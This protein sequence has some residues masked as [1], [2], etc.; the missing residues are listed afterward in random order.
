M[1]QIDVTPAQYFLFLIASHAQAQG[2]H[3]R[4][5]TV[6]IKGDDQIVRLFN[7]LPGIVPRTE[8]GLF[9]RGDDPR[10]LPGAS[11]L[12]RAVLRCAL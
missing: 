1:N 2:I 8:G 7:E 5:T 3:K 10:F 9:L 12:S 11:D 6:G 4:E